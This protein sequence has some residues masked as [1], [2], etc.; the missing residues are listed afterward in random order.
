MADDD[1][2]SSSDSEDEFLTTS[3]ATGTGGGSVATDRE[4][5]VRKKLLESFYGKRAIS[6]RNH[7]QDT[8]RSENKRHQQPETIDDGNDHDQATS[9]SGYSQNS[10]N[11]RFDSVTLNSVKQAEALIRTATTHELL[12]TEEKLYLQVRT[13]DST[14]QTLVYENYS[15]FI[16]ATDAIRSIGINVTA[17]ESGL[18]QLTQAM[19]AIQEHSRVVDEAVGTLRDQV[20]EKIRVQRL[21]T[22][23]DTLLNLPTTLQEQIAVGRYRVATLSYLQAASVL[24]KHSEGFE[25]LKSIETECHAIL[26]RLQLDLENKMMHW[27]GRASAAGLETAYSDDDN[28]NA[29]TNESIDHEDGSTLSKNVFNKTDSVDVPKLPTN[30]AEVFECAGALF[31]LRQEQDRKTLVGSTQVGSWMESLYTSTMGAA[32]RLLDRLLDA[33]LI[34]VQER[35]FSGMDLDCSNRDFNSPRPEPVQPNGASLAPRDVLDA[36][37][38]GAILFGTSFT[39]TDKKSTAGPAHNFILEFVTVSFS[40][41]IAHVRSI[42]AEES[43]Q[44]SRDSNTSDELNNS[45]HE[46]VSQALVLLVQYVQDLAS[47][48]I[49]PSVGVGTDIAAKFVDQTVELAESVVNRRVDQ[50]FHELRLSVVKD[51]LVPFASRAVSERN[52]ALKDGKTVHPLIVQLASSMLSDCMQLVDDTIRGIFASSTIVSGD[53]PDF[54]DLKDATHASTNKFASWLANTFEILAG[55]DSIDAS[56]LAE[57]PLQNCS[58]ESKQAYEDEGMEGFDVI[59][60]SKV[61]NDE[62]GDVFSDQEL[63]HMMLGAREQLSDDD[64]VLHSDFILAIVDLCR[65]SEV[66]VSEN[67]EQS[68]TTHLGVGKKKSRGIFPSDQSEVAD[69]SS[70]ESETRKC[71]KLAGSRVLFLYTLNTGSV[72]AGI[73]SNGLAELSILSD[74]DIPSAPS[75][76]ALAVVSAAKQ[77]AIEC[78][79]IFG[80]SKCGGPVPVW[81]E[82]SHIL[83]LSSHALM[84]SRK[85][86]LQLDVERMFKETVFIYPHPSELMEGTRNAVLFLFFKVVFRAMFE[87]ARLNSFSTGGYR[88]FQVD[89]IF[90]KHMLPHYLSSEFTEKGTNGC[91]ALSTLMDDVIE[92][93]NDRCADE[94]RDDEAMKQESREIVRSFITTVVDSSITCQF[95][96]EE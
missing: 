35:K 27:S 90:L 16:D 25:S 40:S 21:L 55:G 84:S 52:Q 81:D 34:Q 8:R 38:E 31:I 26:E 41:F 93:V 68:F 1:F 78:S 2:A 47:D 59:T 17:N 29:D 24:A 51:C 91:N 58:N 82:N 71:F 67:L 63:M 56:L 42:L 46:E 43:I 54:L 73:I 44:A 96:I 74:H 94:S 60:N 79:H 69:A 57:A 9:A 30:M 83:S 15:R 77:T 89:S 62:D 18:H 66:S 49:N 33:H 39:Q 85:T 86:G 64:G 37:L 72:V 48:L 32:I 36:L 20:A 28:D 5:L 6:E 76:S 61:L 11:S 10:G 12:A 87:N 4:A 70:D 22:R 92:V 50:T 95:I 14:M 65:F 53:F 13:L 88:Q 3:N 19:S 23:L 45:S 80:G 75:S 7:T